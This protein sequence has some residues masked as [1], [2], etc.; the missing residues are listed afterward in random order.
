MND[1][2]KICPLCNEILYKDSETCFTCGYQFAEDENDFVNLFIRRSSAI[3]DNDD[4]Y[5]WC[6]HCDDD[7]LTL[8]I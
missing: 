7:L 3:W 2:I 5:S 8:S 4:I 1:K 6:K